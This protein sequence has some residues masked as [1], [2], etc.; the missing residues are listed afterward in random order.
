MKHI[1]ATGPSDGW[2]DPRSHFEATFSDKGVAYS[3]TYFFHGAEFDFRISKQASGKY[4]MR[5]YANAIS[6]LDDHILQV[7]GAAKAKITAEL[8]E[9]KPGYIASMGEKRIPEFNIHC[10]IYCTTD[11]TD[12]CKA[13]IQERI[14]QLYKDH[15]PYIHRVYGEVVTR[16]TITP[17]LAAVC[18]VDEYMKANH[19]GLNKRSYAKLRDCIVD[20]CMLLPHKPMCKFTEREIT[21][22]F[23][24]IKVSKTTQKRIHD[25]WRYCLD[26]KLCSGKIPFPAEPRK[27]RDPDKEFR[28]GARPDFLDTTEQFS[29]YEQC[30]KTPSGPNCGVALMLWGG[31]SAA[32]AC[33]LVWGDVIW[34]PD[35]DYIRIKYFRMDLV[36]ATH[37]YTAPLFPFAASILAQRY[38]ALQAEHTT[39]A[40]ATMPIVSKIKSP[41]ESIGASALTQHATRCLQ[42]V[43][44]THAHLDALRKIDP[45]VSASARMLQA[46]YANNLY[47]L[48]KLESEPGTAKFLIRESLSFSTTDDHYTNFADEDAGQHL[49]DIMSVLQPEKEIIVD[50]GPTLLATGMECRAFAPESTLHRTGC[51]ADYR[52]APGE[53]LVIKCPHGVTGSARVRGYTATGELRRAPKSK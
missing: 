26:A 20:I 47:V 1:P 39:E 45:S 12:E 33:E 15:A 46:T 18:H 36:G 48:C 53:E 21:S 34:Y 10:K 24:G 5:G 3:G 22:L 42:D 38:C 52:L 37:D 14:L 28:K 19:H 17:G 30:S 29:L 25:F 43:G 32:K 11:N 50:E 51:I 27:P 13:H 9:K 16:D 4:V 6:P 44:V 2:N 41:K 7:A 49:H 23:S 8:E 40:L 31:F 35:P